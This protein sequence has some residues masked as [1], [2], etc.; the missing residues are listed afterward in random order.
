MN[1]LWT[2]CEQVIYKTR[3]NGTMIWVLL[4]E[5]NRQQRKEEKTSTNSCILVAKERIPCSYFVLF[6]WYCKSYCNFEWSRVNIPTENGIHDC[7]IAILPY[8]IYI[9]SFP[10]SL[11][12]YT[13]SLIPYLIS[14]IPYPLSLVPISQFQCP[15]SQVSSPIS[16][17]PCPM[18]HVPFPFSLIPCPLSPYP[19]SLIQCPLSLIP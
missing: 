8:P 14:F 3:K 19:P 10:I 13:L 2:G 17:I 11:I 4:Y 6:I 12:L 16:H 15:L 9:R 5:K 18:S 1:I 7:H